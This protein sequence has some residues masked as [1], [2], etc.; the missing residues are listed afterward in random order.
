MYTLILAR[1]PS[2]WAVLSPTRWRPL[3]G[4]RGLDPGSGS[5]LRLVGEYKSGRGAC[6]QSQF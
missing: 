3:E 4:A 5:V 2:T 6:L 1:C